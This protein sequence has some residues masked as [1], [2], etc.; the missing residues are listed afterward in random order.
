MAAAR[1]ALESSKALYR[2]ALQIAAIADRTAGNVASRFEIA[3]RDI[4]AEIGSNP[5]NAAIL[6]DRH[7]AL[8]RALAAVAG[9]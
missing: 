7:D 9:R 1:Q 3:L 5:R 2:R 8:C 6:F 4:D